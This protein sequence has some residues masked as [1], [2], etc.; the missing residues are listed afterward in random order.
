[1]LPVY[2]SK[3]LAFVSLPKLVVV[4]H[5]SNLS[6]LSEN[7]SETLNTDKSELNFI[8]INSNLNVKE[9]VQFGNKEIFVDEKLFSQINNLEKDSFIYFDEYYQ[10]LLQNLQISGP[11]SFLDI[12]D[13]KLLYELGY[14]YFTNLFHTKS[15]SG[16][17]Y[18]TGLASSVFRKEQ[19]ISLVSDSYSGEGLVSIYTSSYIGRHAPDNSKLLSS[20]FF[21][22]GKT[23]LSI[24]FGIDEEHE[25]TITKSERVRVNLGGETTKVTLQTTG[26]SYQ[27]NIDEGEY[28]FFIDLRD[29]PT[30]SKNILETKIL[31]LQ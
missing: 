27:F 6:V 10:N 3:F 23:N 14:S 15:L 19:L 17:L 31:P 9:Q 18:F 24:D 26:K 21:G 7:L 22:A 4:P 25:M 28:G 2:L 29:K 8:N 1:M 11:A 30:K 12:Q 16:K 20:I 13:Q 5:F